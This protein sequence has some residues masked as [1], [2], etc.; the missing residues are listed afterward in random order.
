MQC[1]RRRRHFHRFH[2]ICWPG[3]SSSLS[4][5]SS[6]PPKLISQEPKDAKKKYHR[7]RIGDH[8]YSYNSKFLSFFILFFSFSLSFSFILGVSWNGGTENHLWYF[9]IYKPA[10]LGIPRGNGNPQNLAFARGQ[11]PRQPRFQRFWS[12]H[13]SRSKRW[14]SKKLRA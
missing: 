8:D 4:V 13:I 6:S 3:Y 2:R 11:R 7:E 1:W 14:P 9:R 5:T 12:R 10:I